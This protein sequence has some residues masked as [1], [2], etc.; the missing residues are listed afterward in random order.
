MF[1][2]SHASTQ[3]TPSLRWSAS[4]DR[5]YGR[6]G[7]VAT[8]FQLPELHS[9]GDACNAMAAIAHA[10]A[11]GE[12]TALEAAELSRLVDAYVKA[13]E[14]TDFDRRLRALE[15]RNATNQKG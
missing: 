13:I 9:A 12:L 11:R 4:L 2:T 15:E 6:P 3:R 7:P 14:C 10:T 8:T 5:G 1:A